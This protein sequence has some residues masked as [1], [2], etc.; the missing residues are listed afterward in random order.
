MDGVT[1]DACA[2]AEGRC[3]VCDRG[4]GWGRVLRRRVGVGPSREQV[5]GDLLAARLRGWGVGGA[6]RGGIR[7]RREGV[8]ERLSLAHGKVYGWLASGAGEG[9]EIYFKGGVGVEEGGG[10]VLRRRWARG[11]RTGGDLRVR[12]CAPSGR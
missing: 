2:L 10:G 5:C 6:G 3:E 7:E 4:I 8:E 9:V 11:T 1:A 12:R